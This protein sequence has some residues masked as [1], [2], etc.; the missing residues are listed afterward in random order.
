MLS[1]GLLGAPLECRVCPTANQQ[2]LLGACCQTDSL[3]LTTAALQLMAN[4]LRLACFQELSLCHIDHV[5]PAA[6]GQP[7]WGPCCQGYCL[8]LIHSAMQL[9]GN[10]DWGRAVEEIGA[11][12]QYLRD[13]GANKVAVQGLWLT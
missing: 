12:A 8:T 9:M 1:E 13:Q 4:P 10:L 7:P 2:P 5:C 11:A 6:G 3:T